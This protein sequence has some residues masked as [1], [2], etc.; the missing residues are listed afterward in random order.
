MGNFLYVNKCCSCK[1]NKATHK[2]TIKYDIP[3][4]ECNYLIIAKIKPIYFNNRLLLNNR[5]TCNRS[6]TISECNK[7][8]LSDYRNCLEFLNYIPSNDTYER[9]L[10]TN[11]KNDE[12]DYNFYGCDECMKYRHWTYDLLEKIII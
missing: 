8:I 11:I 6:I 3:E 12:I 5:C 2:K 9:D 10:I 4:C 7:K 1:I